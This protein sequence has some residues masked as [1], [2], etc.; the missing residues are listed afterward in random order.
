MLLKKVKM[1]KITTLFP[2]ATYIRRRDKLISSAEQ[3]ANNLY[4]TKPK[5]I[6]G[7]SNKDH[8]QVLLAWGE[9][10]NMAFHTEMNRLWNIKKK[11]PPSYCKCSICGDIHVL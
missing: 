3:H 5:R 2:D 11:S 7:S 1:N 8:E 10:W 6:E 9:K 4:G